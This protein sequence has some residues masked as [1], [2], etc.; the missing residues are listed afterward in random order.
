MHLQTA[1]PPASLFYQLLQDLSQNVDAMSA[2][3]LKID[4]LPAGAV[5][6]P[7]EQLDSAWLVQGA[8]QEPRR[9]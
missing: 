8:D 1:V 9:L 7:F 3:R 6:G 2:G 5:V 4:V